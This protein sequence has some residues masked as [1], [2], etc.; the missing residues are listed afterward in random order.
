[1]TKPDPRDPR[2]TAMARDAAA[3]LNDTRF[4][5]WR[6]ARRRRLLVVAAALAIALTVAAAWYGN[7]LL[8]LPA[9][10][11]AGGAWWLLRQVVR[12]MA[13]LPDEFVDE[14]IRSVRNEHYL[15]AYR[16]LSGLVALAT[17]AMYLAADATRVGWQPGADQ[18]HALF[19]GVLLLAGML[20][21]MLLAWSQ[22][23]V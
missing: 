6:A 21:S 9:L 3:M 4:D 10:A 23:E 14:R 11:L 22:R 19:W 17:L 2:E 8:F 5:G 13:D 7:N 1:M 12:G 20:P 18:L 16:A 15:Y